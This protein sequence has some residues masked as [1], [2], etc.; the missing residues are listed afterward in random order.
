MMNT[1][2]PLIKRAPIKDGFLEQMTLSR[3]KHQGRMTLTEAKHLEQ[4]TQSEDRHQGRMTLTDDKHQNRLN[5][6][7]I[8]RLLTHPTR[9]M[10]DR[11]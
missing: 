10:S 11:G 5:D 6:E 1:E 7:W 8:E 4:M 2:Q 9:S 3:D